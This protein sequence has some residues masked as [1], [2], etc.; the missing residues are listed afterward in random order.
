MISLIIGTK[1]HGKT[2]KLISMVDEAVKTS[3]GNVV[4]VEKKANLGSNIT[5]R[6][7]LVNTDSYRIN[8]YSDFY[9]FLAGVCAGNY[10]VTDIFV[11]ATFKIIGRDYNELVVFLK[12]VE[13]LSK[14]SGAKFVFTISED[15]EKLPAEIFDFCEEVKD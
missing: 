8:G 7:R 1:G 4:V 14:E 5:T 2:K 11:D 13:F 10:D 15:K 12:E 3:L 6:A 9:G